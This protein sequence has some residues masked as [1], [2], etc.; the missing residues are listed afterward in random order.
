MRIFAYRLGP[1][2]RWR[3][4]RSGN[5]P[6]RSGFLAAAFA[7][8]VAA[9]AWGS[10]CG[11]EPTVQ[12]SV[13]IARP[14]GDVYDERT[15]DGD[16]YPPSLGVRGSV[17]V[18]RYALILDYRRNVFL[19]ESRGANS[20]TRYARIEGGFDTTA[21]F[22]AR[23]TSFEAR[24][25]R[26]IAVTIPLYAGVGIVRTWSNYHYPSLTGIGAGV[27]LRPAATGAVVPFASAF[28]YPSASGQY[29]TETLPT[30]RMKPA[31]GILKLDAGLVLRKPR[32]A[33]Y[34]AFGYANEIRSA[35]ALPSDIRFIRSD[36]YA[37]VGF[38]L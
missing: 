26:R 34:A 30:R 18:N 14:L 6:R 12:A 10:P 2:G 32:S 28:Y 36:P 31:F 11:A 19:T 27:E 38:R 23:E 37:A 4:R 15:T 9:A 20:L 29:A 33:L 16:A 3:A 25:E 7:L 21:P 1:R 5:L 24:F 22:L 17:G 35:Y 8:L 13:E